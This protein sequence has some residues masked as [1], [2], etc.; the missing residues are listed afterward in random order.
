MTINMIGFSRKLDNEF[1]KKT[2]QAPN[3]L[4]KLCKVKR[5][6]SQEMEKHLSKREKKIELIWE[7]KWLMVDHLGKLVATPLQKGK[8]LQLKE[9]LK[10]V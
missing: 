4:L 5:I 2:W 1:Q 9:E 10:V 7:H 3:K 6:I 8:H